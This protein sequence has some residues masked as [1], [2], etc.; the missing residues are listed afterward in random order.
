MADIRDQGF[1]L[2]FNRGFG[3]SGR[4]GFT[5]QTYDPEIGRLGLAANRQM[6][7]QRERADQ[8]QRLQQ[9]Q[10]DLQR[11]LGD[12]GNATQRLGIQTN[13]DTA[14]YQT[15]RE[16]AS[17]Q[18]IAGMNNSTQRYQTDRTTDQRQRE[19][20][21]QSALQREGFTLQDRLNERT[22]EA[23][24]LP[25]ILEQGRFDRIFPILSGQLASL[26]GGG[27]DYSAGY[28]GDGPV[29]QQP[30][31]SDAP[32]YTDAQ[33]QEQ[34]NAQRAAND[35]TAA[36]Q[37]A[38]MRANLAGRGYGANSPLAQLLGQNF[39]S[40]ALGASAANERETR[41]GAAGAN[42]AQVLKAQQAR[43]SQYASRQAEDIE[44]NKTSQSN[45]NALMSALV[46]LV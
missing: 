25:S 5:V 20:E 45:R 16:T 40:Q 7:A 6:Y 44:R 14:R 36:G 26:N 3:S 43:E 8:Q 19:S 12:Q 24:K 28:R 30:A 37:A 23:Q 4:S 32:V 34:V 21:L 39:M 10:L 41:L 29:G 46:G 11:Y 42:A 31:I 38:R 17:Q 18:R 15:D 2:N 9:P 13:S 22:V 27:G 35:Q 1:G 33:T